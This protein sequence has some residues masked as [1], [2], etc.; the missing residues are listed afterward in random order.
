M[1]NETKTATDKHPRKLRFVGT[2]LIAAVAL[3]AF[4]SFYYFSAPQLDAQQ[5]AL[6]AWTGVPAPDFAVTN[7][8]GRSFH[9]ADLKGRRVILNFWATWCP[10]CQ[11]EIPDF[12]K[13][14]AQTSP[15]N[16]VILGLSA[17]DA[18]TQKAFAQRDKIN[19]PLAV[20]QNV[21]SPYQDIAEIPVTMAIDR[22]G[23][24][25]NAVLGPQEL[26]TLEQFA[27][28]PDYAGARKSIPVAKGQ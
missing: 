11:E 1:N 15:T 6:L 4:E 20:L 2:L 10:P 13:L 22:N 8:D 14:R 18:A 9:L 25:Q 5:K 7:L 24:I 3:L 21:P 26:K 12:I 23:V 17:D 27:T 19:Y 28:E 16:V